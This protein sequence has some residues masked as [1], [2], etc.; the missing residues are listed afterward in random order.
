MIH[1]YGVYGVCVC[2]FDLIWDEI[3]FLGFFLFNFL[4]VSRG[5]FLGKVVSENGREEEE[6]IHGAKN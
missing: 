1:I 4:G 2:G 3:L 6:V 5:N